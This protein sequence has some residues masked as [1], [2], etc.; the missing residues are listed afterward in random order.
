MDFGSLNEFSIGKTAVGAVFV[1]N[2]D[3]TDDLTVVGHVL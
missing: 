2:E 1:V 3:C